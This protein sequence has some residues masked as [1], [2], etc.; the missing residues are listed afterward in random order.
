MAMRQSGLVLKL[1]PPAEPV[2]LQEGHRS[3]SAGSP[4]ITQDHTTITDTDTGI[5]RTARHDLLKDWMDSHTRVL[6]FWLD[7][8]VE[9][10][11]EADLISM[12][13]RQHAWLCLMQARLERG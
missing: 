13:H 7:R 12:V 10:G 4:V 5:T 2:S 3:G 9:E 6:G 1:V 11:D 8:L